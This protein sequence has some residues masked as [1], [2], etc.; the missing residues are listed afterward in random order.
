MSKHVFHIYCV[1]VE[2]E[3]RLSKE[4]FMWELYTGKRHQSVVALHAH[5]SHDGLPQ[6][7]PRAKA[8]VQWLNRLFHKYVSLPIHPRM[9][10]EA[11]RYVT[12]SIRELA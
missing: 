10:E 1:L 5:P 9:T 2:P 12:D 6:A 4:D 7:G 3:F 8:N 11:I